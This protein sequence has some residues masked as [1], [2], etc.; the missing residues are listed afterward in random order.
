[1]GGEFGV[2]LEWNEERELDWNLLRFPGHAGVQRLLSDLNRLYRASPPLWRDDFSPSGF[3]W[4]DCNDRDRSIIN[5]LRHDHG[6]GRSLLIV[7]NFTPVP[8]EGYRIGVPVAGRWRERI[9]SDSS[10][11]GGSNLGNVGEVETE[12]VECMGRKFSLNLTLPPLSVLI[13][14]PPGNSRS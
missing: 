1:M 7:C 11:Y 6:H 4:V 2:T 9:N 13:L 3:E 14:E 5:F 10:M 12:A 8:R